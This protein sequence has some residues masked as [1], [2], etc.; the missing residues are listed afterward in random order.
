MQSAIIQ[1]N[2]TEQKVILTLTIW[3]LLS[4]FLGYFE[5]VWVKY[6]DPFLAVCVVLI[7]TTLIV[8]YFKNKSFQSFS[9]HISLKSIA[10]FHSLGEF[11]QVGFSYRSVTNFQK[12]SLTML[13]MEI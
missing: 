12:H 9:N 4:F 13:L 6:H 5:I 7:L 8:L 1:K 2:S 11:L 3:G 10:L